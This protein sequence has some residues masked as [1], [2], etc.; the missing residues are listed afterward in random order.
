MSEDFGAGCIATCLIDNHD[1][2]DHI[3][4]Y[5]YLEF[6]PGYVYYDE[7]IKSPEWKAKAD[8]AKARVGKCQLCS[9]VSNLQA[10]HNNYDHL[11]N[12]REEDITVLCGRHH[13]E[14]SKRE[15][16]VKYLHELPY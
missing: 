5:W 8:E 14:Y 2:D 13:E 6:D 9:G 16:E 3:P 7:Y 10:H 12:E 4:D 15:K 1:C 11:G